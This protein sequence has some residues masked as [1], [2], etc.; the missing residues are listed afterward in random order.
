MESFLTY[1]VSISNLEN[2]GSF[3]KEQKRAHF[4]DEGFQ[5]VSN[6]WKIHVKQFI[7]WVAAR[8]KPADLLKKNSDKGIC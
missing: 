7:F 5:S 4:R 2:K 1:C 6:S 3:L 8:Y